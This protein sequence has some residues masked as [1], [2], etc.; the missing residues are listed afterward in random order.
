MPS[1]AYTYRQHN[2]VS[3]CSRAFSYGCRRSGAMHDPPLLAGTSDA[4]GT[5]T[6]PPYRKKRGKI[7]LDAV[8]ENMHDRNIYRNLHNFSFNFNVAKPTSTTV[9]MQ[10]EWGG[11]GGSGTDENK[12]Q[13]DGTT[14]KGNSLRGI[15][16]LSH[17]THLK[18]CCSLALRRASVYAVQGNDEPIQP[19][20][21]LHSQ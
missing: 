7:R 6:H 3:H 11:G 20:A 21:C 18:I 4:E 9:A 14:A 16:K 2:T 13:N 19:L 15:L 5:T 10:Q 17:S 8:I 12:N 1:R